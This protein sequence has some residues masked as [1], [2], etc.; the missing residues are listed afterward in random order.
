LSVH[1]QD[2]GVLMTHD[3]EAHVPIPPTGTDLAQE[4]WRAGA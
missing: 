2:I 4:A 3:F 1:H